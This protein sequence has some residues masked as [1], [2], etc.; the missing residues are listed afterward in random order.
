M[1]YDMIR[2]YKGRTQTEDD[3]RFIKSVLQNGLDIAC[4]HLIVDERQYC[5]TCKYRTACKEVRGSISYKKKRY[6]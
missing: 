6:E 2:I 3:M 4:S 1:K 5:E